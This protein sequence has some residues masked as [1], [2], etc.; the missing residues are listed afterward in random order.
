VKAGPL[1]E[2]LVVGV[3]RS[4]STSLSAYLRN[5]PQAHV[6]LQKEVHYFDR[7]YHRGE[8]WYRRQFAEARP[9]QRPGE[10]T[11]GY[12][13]NH[14]SMERMHAL[15][16]GA[17]LVVCLRHPVDRAWSHY[18]LYRT[19][20]PS[21]TR[22]FEAWLDIE[23]ADVEGAALGYLRHGLYHRNL[24]L[25][26]QHW[27]RESLLLFLIE[28][29]KRDAAAVFADVCGHIG[30]DPGLAPV[31]VGQVRHSLFAYKSQT[32]RK[33][34]LALAAS[35]R[36]LPLAWRLDQRNR[37]PFTPPEM[38]PATRDR[39][40]SFF[41]EDTKRLEQLLGRDLSAWRQ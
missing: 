25:A 40:L 2:W 38:A 17:R 4:A 6:A 28:D 5:H 8:A 11:P 19:Y 3:P 29:L 37:V 21:D 35:R 23:E 39:L 41:A 10:A 22:S 26:L 24:T 13:A 7:H 30:I 20:L 33:A 27:P 9:G 1:P 15:V 34:I 32:A 14:P 16:P 31:T 18:W 36:L 12:L